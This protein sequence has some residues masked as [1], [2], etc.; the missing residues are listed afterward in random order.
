MLCK[1]DW[2]LI[3]EETAEKLVLNNCKGVEED[4][5][6]DWEGVPSMNN[7]RFRTFNV[8]AMAGRR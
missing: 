5:L 6:L 1:Q 4:R 3:A 2:A 7:F 8:V